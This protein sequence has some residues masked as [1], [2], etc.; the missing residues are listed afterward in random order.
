MDGLQT[1]VDNVLGVAGAIDVPGLLVR[2]DDIFGS[3]QPPAL[4]NMGF[5]QMF[6]ELIEDSLLP[7]NDPDYKDISDINVIMD[8]WVNEVPPSVVN[9]PE[10][11]NILAT[12]FG[13][14]V[15]MS[16]LT[17]AIMDMVNDPQ[18]ALAAG[19][20][21]FTDIASLIDSFFGGSLPDGDYEVRIDSQDEAGN[22][23]TSEVIA[24]TIDTNAS[25]TID[26]P[27]DALISAAES[28]AVVVS[29]TTVANVAVFDG[30]ATTIQSIQ[31][32]EAGRDITVT[33]SDGSSNVI[34][35]VQVQGD[36]TWTVTADISGLNNGTI[37][38][39]ATGTDLAGN[40]ANADENS[41]I[42]LDTIAPFLD[43][44]GLDT[45]TGDSP[46]DLVTSDNTPLGYGQTEVGS[47]VRAFILHQGSEILVTC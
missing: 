36:G 4:D 5:L 29:G 31:T 46:F 1:A 40:V 28:T 24:F 17:D 10:I 45:D 27:A 2:I 20:A 12:M 30:V 42:E 25:V 6:G 35:V 43:V 14:A 33:F 13:P 15:N 23:A 41:D 3:G 47:T 32:I 39:N 9:V 37:T 38:V 44:Q 8:W 34:E 11:M 16:D 21:A 7:I 22:N 19:E 18:A 26:A